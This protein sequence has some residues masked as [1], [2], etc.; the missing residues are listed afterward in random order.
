VLLVVIIQNF[1]DYLDCDDPPRILRSPIADYSIFS[2]EA[3]NHLALHE[4][5]LDEK[6]KTHTSLGD[7]VTA[8]LYK[9]KHL[10]L[11]WLGYAS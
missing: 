2:M 11:P 1:Y 10:H 4:H 6:S 7:V 3:K 5:T 8:H 9:G